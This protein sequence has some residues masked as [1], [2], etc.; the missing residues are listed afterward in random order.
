MIPCRLLS[1][2]LSF[3]SVV[4][5]SIGYGRNAL[6]DVVL[7]SVFMDH[8]RP[9]ILKRLS[10]LQITVFHL[11][12]IAMLTMV[13]DHLALAFF[14]NNIGMRMIGR[15]A[16][17]IYALLIAEGYRH[18]RN[19]PAKLESHLKF[20]LITMVI[21]E[22]T[23]DWFEVPNFALPDIL[24]TQSAIP[25]LLLGM[26]CL[27]VWDRWRAWYYRAAVVLSC[28]YA[29]YLMQS[30]F[31]LGGVVLIVGLFLYL[32]RLEAGMFTAWLSRFAALLIVFIIYTMV[33][34]LA[35][36]NFTTTAP[37]VAS[38][39]NLTNW[40]KY[41]MGIPIAALFA[42][43]RGQLGT[44]IPLFKTI[45]KWFYPVHF[46]GIAILRWVVGIL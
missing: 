19:Q 38:L 24:Q 23:Y 45:Y 42:C 16:F 30:N 17:P 14:A 34:H 37:Y 43:Y 5:T 32:E 2:S 10:N 31:P 1:A 9:T 39:S 11:Q 44:H 20:Y 6:Y 3:A 26:I 4:P 21:S 13:V 40:T 28:S 18:L 7:E 35:R 46:A 29:T 27:I 25:T 36:T 15:F 33:Y 8:A 12:A 22:L 41:I